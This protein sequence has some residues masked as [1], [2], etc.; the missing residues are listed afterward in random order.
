M[1]LNTDAIYDLR[2]CLKEDNPGRNY[3]KRDDYL[4]GAGGILCDLT[5]IPS[6]KCVILQAC[7]I[8]YVYNHLYVIC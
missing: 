7:V 2:V 5:H 3:T 8:I 6:L 1:K 4:Y